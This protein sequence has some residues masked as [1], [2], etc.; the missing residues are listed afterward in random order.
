[1]KTNLMIF[2]DAIE[3][4]D[5]DGNKSLFFYNNPN[6]RLHFL[7]DVLSFSVHTTDK[8]DDDYYIQNRVLEITNWL[9]ANFQQYTWPAHEVHFHTNFMQ[10][11]GCPFTCMNEISTIVEKLIKEKFAS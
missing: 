8:T 5:N 10:H 4:V 2:R 7:R 9:D 3:S 6:A 11:C 1:M